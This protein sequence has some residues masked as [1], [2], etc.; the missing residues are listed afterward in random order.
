MARIRGPE[1]NG[2]DSVVVRQNAVDGRGVLDLALR[3][4]VSR[5]PRVPG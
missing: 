5:N 4:T 2:L 1:P 3:P